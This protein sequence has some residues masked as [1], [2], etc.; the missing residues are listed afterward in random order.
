MHQTVKTRVFDK[1]VVI[2]M[3]FT[4][5]ELKNDKIIQLSASDSSL[6]PAAHI[7]FN[8]NV[9]NVIHKNN[10]LRCLILLFLCNLA[11]NV[12]MAYRDDFLNRFCF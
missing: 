11:L 10:S 6:F 12:C 1:D 7:I 4:Q 2:D 8:K 9:L 3:Y 5:I